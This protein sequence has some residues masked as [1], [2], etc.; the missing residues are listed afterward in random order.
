MS[1]LAQI[2]VTG[3]SGDGPQLSA[4]FR[5]ARSP[6]GCSEFV[7]G[8]S[9]ADFVK[10]LEPPRRMLIMVKAGAPTDG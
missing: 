2:G 7:P 4:E 9:M 5:S 3:F 10:S 1:D 8:M 6:S